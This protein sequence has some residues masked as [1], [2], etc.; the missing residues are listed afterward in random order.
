M[1]IVR[2]V[3][4]A[5]LGPD[6]DLTYAMNHV[7]W[8]SILENSFG[9]INCCLPVLQPVLGK[10]VGANGWTSRNRS[11]NGYN[12]SYESKSIQV[13]TEREVVLSRNGTDDGI[14]LHS[15]EPR[16]YQYTADVRMSPQGH[17]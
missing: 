13:V 11:T 10:L 3:S 6:S 15:V 17:R 2:I 14:P 8:W 16:D 4:L 1:S 9:V 7:G 12:R 5:A